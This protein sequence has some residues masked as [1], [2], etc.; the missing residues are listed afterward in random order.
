MFLFNLFKKKTKN[1]CNKSYELVES[2][3]DDDHFRQGIKLLDSIYKDIV[4]TVSPKVKIGIID[5]CLTITYDIL[6]EENPNHI[7]YVYDELH[8]YMGEIIME[9]VEKDIHAA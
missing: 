8:L 3:I 1:K 6:V 4:V 7:S 2:K 5:D 9:M